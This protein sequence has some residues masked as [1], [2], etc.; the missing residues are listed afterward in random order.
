MRNDEIKHTITLRLLDGFWPGA[1]SIV[2]GVNSWDVTFLDE[3][4]NMAEEQQQVKPSTPAEVIG[5]AQEAAQTIVDGLVT[6][7][8]AHANVNSKQD[9]V[10]RKEDEV[11]KAKD[12][13]AAE[14]SSYNQVVVTIRAAADALKESVERLPRFQN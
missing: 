8:T 13:A 5:A 7:S 2:H 9:I 3:G 10:R 4:M 1:G 6:L 12:D 11:Q 14:A